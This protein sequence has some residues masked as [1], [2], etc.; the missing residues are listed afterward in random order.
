VA[1]QVIAGQSNVDQAGALN[2]TQLRTKYQNNGIFLQEEANINDVLVLTAGGR[3][4]ESSNNGNVDII[5]STPRRVCR[6]I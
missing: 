3:L 2:A 4:D 6:G 1:T 5:I